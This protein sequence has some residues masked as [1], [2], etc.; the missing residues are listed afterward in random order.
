MM[1]IHQERLLTHIGFGIQSHRNIVGNLS[2]STLTPGK[3][4][5]HAS[6]LV[7]NVEQA[8]A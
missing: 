1:F 3:V 2:K 5:Y 8:P 6:K 7:Q 4:A